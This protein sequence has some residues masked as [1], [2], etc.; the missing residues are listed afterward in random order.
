[1]MSLIVDADKGDAW[2]RTERS[3]PRS[4]G[5]EVDGTNRETKHAT[6]Y[7]LVTTENVNETFVFD[8]LMNMFSSTMNVR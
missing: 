6:Q 2:K 3:N 4:S 8:I 5:K 1:M 7:D